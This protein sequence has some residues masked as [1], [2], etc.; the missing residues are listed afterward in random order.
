[1]VLIAKK[2]SRNGADMPHI[3]TS[4]TV[5]ILGPCRFRRGGAQEV[6]VLESGLPYSVCEVGCQGSKQADGMVDA[7]MTSAFHY[8]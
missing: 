6:F 4:E 8:P 7:D 1:M 3:V 2:P 5:V